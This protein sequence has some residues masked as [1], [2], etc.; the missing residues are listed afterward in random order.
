MVSSLCFF[1][2]NS[3]RYTEVSE[4]GLGGLRGMK[5][6]GGGGGGGDMDFSGDP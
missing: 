5:V 6:A 1:K 2:C 3:Y 4:S